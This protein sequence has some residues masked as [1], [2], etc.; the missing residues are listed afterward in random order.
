[1]SLVD[2]VTSVSKPI[3]C[4]LEY[5]SPI[6]ELLLRLWA[7]NV[8]WKSGINKF[9]SMDTT[10]MLFQYEYA[11]PLVSPTVAAYMGTAVELIFPVLLAIGLAGRFAAMVLFI[12][13]ITAVLFYPALEL[14]GQLQHLM[15]GIMLL[16]ACLHGP[17]KISIDHFIRRRMLS[18]SP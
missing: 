10:I 4:G 1:M 3:I 9:Q 14:P 15:W 18:A 6:S 16:V 17:G 13:N 8:F 7:C 11:V 2:K 12:F 5:L